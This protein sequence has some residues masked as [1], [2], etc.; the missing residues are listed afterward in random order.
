MTKRS[1]AAAD[2]RS[3][4][5]DPPSVSQQRQPEHEHEHEE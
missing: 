1:G 4:A 5:G 2:V 3:A